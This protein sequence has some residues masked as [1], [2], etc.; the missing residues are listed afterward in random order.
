MQRVA[1][2]GEPVDQRLVLTGRHIDSGVG[3]AVRKFRRGRPLTPRSSETPLT[4][5]H[6]RGKRFG[7]QRTRFRVATAAAQHNDGVLALPLVLDVGDLGD[8]RQFSR[9]RQRRMQPDALGAV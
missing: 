4:P 1:V 5:K 9:R 3:V 8:H 2:T 6:Q 7:N